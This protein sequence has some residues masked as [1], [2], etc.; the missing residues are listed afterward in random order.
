MDRNLVW[1]RRG[2]LGVWVRVCIIRFVPSLFVLFWFCPIPNDLRLDRWLVDSQ[3]IAFD[4]HRQMRAELTPGVRGDLSLPY[5]RD[6]MPTDQRQQWLKG[7][8]AEAGLCRAQAPARGGLCC[9]SISS[10]G[11]GRRV[12]TR[13]ANKAI[14]TSVKPVHGGWPHSK[15]S[16]CHR[17]QLKPALPRPENRRPY[18]Q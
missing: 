14:L 6:S 12:K 8:A 13:Y 16:T 15:V 17:Q 2:S 5:Q 9:P 18:S 7:L 3:Q 1:V 11:S 4:T 10:P